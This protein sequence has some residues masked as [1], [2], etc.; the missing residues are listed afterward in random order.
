[1]VFQTYFTFIKKKKKKIFFFQKKLVLKLFTRGLSF[2]IFKRKTYQANIY[3]KKLN[4]HRFKKK[5]AF[6]YFLVFYLASN[7]TRSYHH[8]HQRPTNDQLGILTSK[9]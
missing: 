2:F 5:W 1:M 3:L 8:P 9:Y 4:K 7:P 6:I